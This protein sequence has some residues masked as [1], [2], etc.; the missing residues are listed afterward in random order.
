MFSR[1]GWAA[2]ALGVA[3]FPAGS[4]AADGEQQMQ[5]G[6]RPRN[7]WM[8][9]DVLRAQDEF[10]G[11][12]RDIL[13]KD[14]SWIYID[15]PEAREIKAHDLVTIIVSEKSE[16][17]ANSRFNRQRTSSLKAELKEF[18]RI[19]PDGRLMT[20]ADNQPT[21]DTN[22]Q[23][24]FQTTGQLSEQEGIT[25]RIAATVV[26]VLPNGNIVLE[27]RK[28]IR[29]NRD[30]WQY[31]LTGIARHADITPD[32]TILSENIANLDI[33]KA[34]KGKVFQSTKRPWG[35]LLYDWFSPF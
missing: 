11:P 6:F 13:I 17:T 22:L 32:N 21:I 31:S 7:D 16:V 5:M 35:T 34:Q 3:L 26:D 2:V 18:I 29:T 1:I 19:G 28:S 23:G 9:G 14:Y 15:I 4:A 20:A 12:Q 30:V 33:V 27:A 10:F 25:Y 24:R 8:Q